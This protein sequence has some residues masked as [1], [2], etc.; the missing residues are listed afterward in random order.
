MKKYRVPR[1]EVFM[2]ETVNADRIIDRVDI[3][4]FVDCYDDFLN[5]EGPVIVG[6]Y[7]LWPAKILQSTDPI[8]YDCGLWDFAESECS[9]IENMAV[10]EERRYGIYVIECLNND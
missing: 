10:G 1:G 9:E 4:E 5:S 7:K 2:F 8:A 3:S 6:G